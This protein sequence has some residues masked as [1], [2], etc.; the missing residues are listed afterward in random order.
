[1]TVPCGTRASI[2]LTLTPCEVSTSAA[3]TLAR[4][5]LLALS[6]GAR[7][8]TGLLLP[9]PFAAAAPAPGAA[10]M[11]SI[12]E[13]MR[14]APRAAASLRSRSSSALR[15]A[16]P[17]SMIGVAATMLGG[18]GRRRRDRRRHQ[19]IVRFW[20][21]QR[22]VRALQYY[23]PPHRRSPRRERLMQPAPLTIRRH[24]SQ[25]N[26]PGRPS[27]CSGDLGLAP[28]D[29]TALFSNSHAPLRKSG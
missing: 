15:S 24:P 11:T 21:G 14:A 8:L 6:S 9:M 25:F 1:M 7:T 18:G 12:A 28:T 26:G 3:E 13:R 22:L 4:K 2:R 5:R 19:S 27:Q 20:P 16:S 17:L 10:S 23:F 29:I